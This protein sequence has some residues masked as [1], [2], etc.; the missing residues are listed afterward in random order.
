MSC[1]FSHNTTEVYLCFGQSNAHEMWA[2]GIREVLT[3]YDPSIV[4]IHQK[5]PGDS[6]TQ[7]YNDG[8]QNNLIEDIAKVESSIE[9]Q[10]LEKYRI[11]GLF[12][13]QGE[14]DDK[15]DLAAQYNERFIGLYTYLKNYFDL[16]ELP[17]EIAQVQINQAEEYAASQANMDL[18]RA[19]QAKL[20][21]ELGLIL[22]DTT[23][24]N[25]RDLYH[26]WASHFTLC[27][28]DMAEKFLNNY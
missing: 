7:W 20:A 27:G 23:D 5:H 9:E 17:T 6:I 16:D 11:A 21:Q 10:N 3:E 4:V 2:D 1:N 15:P 25:R 8:I 12:W 28:K 14:A 24:Y 22:H 19:E 18:I 13:F 26:L